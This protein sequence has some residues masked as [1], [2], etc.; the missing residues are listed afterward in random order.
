MEDTAEKLDATEELVAADEAATTS[1]A[2]QGPAAESGA[3][4]LTPAQ[5]LTTL[6]TQ[7]RNQRKRVAERVTR[8]RT[9]GVIC[10][11]GA[12]EFFSM[13]DIPRDGFYASASDVESWDGN[14]RSGSRWDVSLL[15]F[16]ML[17]NEQGEPDLTC[18]SDLGIQRLLE[19]A[20]QNHGEWLNSVKDRALQAHR[21]GNLTIR[22]VQDSLKFA[23]IAPPQAIT[24]VEVTL[25]WRLAPGQKISRAKHDV[26]ERS[27][28]TAMT[29]VTDGTEPT[30][31]SLT[32]GEQME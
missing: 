16:T 10:S 23:G 31:I 3:A 20:R 1:A 6:L 13:H 9:Q 28:K 24:T 27:I 14:L 11:S 12:A 30:V 2:E 26:L 17:N 19:T 8:L 32:H 29:S 22:T 5:E 4:E 7:I 25:K 21:N 18:Y 15:G